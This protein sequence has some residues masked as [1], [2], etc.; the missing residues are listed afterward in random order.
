M[1]ARGVNKV[2]L[3]GTLGTDPE[4]KFLPNGNAVVNLSMATSEQW[5][6]KNTGAKQE[7]TEW[8]R[9]TF[10][11]KPAEIIAQYAAKG[12][13]LYVEGKLQTRSW[14]QDGVKR[15]MTEIVGSEFQF[16]GGGQD[17]QQQAPAQQQRQAAPQQQA[18]ADD[19]YDDSIPF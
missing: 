18:P 4:Q 13:K 7:K 16:V 19:H 9:V 17:Q 1:A 15:Y 10:F 5:K 11:G 14:E 3:L 2:I 6:D 8:H 12:S